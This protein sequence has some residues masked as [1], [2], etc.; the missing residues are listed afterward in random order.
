MR[1]EIYRFLGEVGSLCP[2]NEGRF[3]SVTSLVVCEEKI[4]KS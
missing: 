3:E 1:A 4:L 2:P